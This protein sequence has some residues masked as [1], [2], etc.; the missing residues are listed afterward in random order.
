MLTTITETKLPQILTVDEKKCVNCHQ[1]IAVCSTKF[2]NDGSGNSVKVNSDLCI[3]C[4]ECIKACTHDARIPIDDLEI[5]FQALAN[6]EKMVAIVAPAVAANFESKYLKLNGWLKSLGVEAFFDVSFGAELTVKSYLQHITSNKPKTVIAQPCP[7]VVSYIEIYKPELIPYLAP[8]D[9]PMLHTVKMIKKYYLKYTNHKVLVLSPC[10]AKKREFADTGFADYNV[11]MNSIEN[12][13]EQNH[14]DIDTYPEI[15]FDNDSAERAVL[16]SSPGGLLSTAEREVNGIGSKTRKIEGP[17]TIYNYLDKLP[18]QITKGRAPLLID[19]LN[20]E[21][22]CNGG[23]GTSNHET[24]ID[25]LEYLIQERKIEMQKVYKTNDNTSTK[26]LK[27]IIDKYWEPNLYNRTYTDK[28]H[29]YKSKI[30]IPDEQELKETF[31]R[32]HKYT[33][34]DIINCASCGYNSCEMMATAIFNN[35]NNPENCHY[36]L[37]HENEEKAEELKQNNEH[38]MEQKTELIEQSESLLNFIEKIRNFIK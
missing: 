17:H 25:E 27:E 9:S 30:K 36:F 11:T 37:S 3:G 38:L 6:R 34:E 20:C 18:E 14:L 1:C 26:K 10:L 15:S 32:M 12:Y 2:A 23:T 31:E 33:D 4:G 29:L 8:A 28:S 7:A 16:F 24:A 35:L 13:F 22:G 5:A 19:C 21:L